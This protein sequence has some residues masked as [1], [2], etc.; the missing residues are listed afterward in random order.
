[1]IK[2]KKWTLIGIAFVLML[3]LSACG[4]NKSAYESL[5]QGTAKLGQADSFDYSGT[6]AFKMDAKPAAGNAEEAQVEQMLS[7]LELKFSGASFKKAKQAT[8]NLELALKGDASL[9]LNVPIVVDQE[10][11]YV[12]VPSIPML[13]LPETVTGKYV[14][15]TKADLEKLSEQAAQENAQKQPKADP[16]KEKQLN[17]ELEA[18]IAKQFKQDDNLIKVSV[19]KSSAEVPAPVKQV[20]E[21]S[22]TNDNF[23]TLVEK[24]VKGLIP[25]ILTVLSKPEYKELTGI[26]TDALKDYQKSLDSFTTEELKKQLTVNKAI[27]QFGIDG[28]GYLSYLRDK[29]D[30][31]ANDE[32]SG[33]TNA[34]ID[35][36][37]NATDINKAKG[38]VAIP[39]ADETI[40]LAQ[41]QEQLG[42]AFSTP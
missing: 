24:I 22:I 40:S 30:F 27:S 34:A 28:S 10:D 29:F 39:K 5:K 15:I 1:M 38:Q 17:K 7:N 31:T 3:S 41:L 26:P 4:Q 23:P 6:L 12:K 14:H 2:F 16:A 25:D 37:F 36:T 20:V 21:Y 19:K 9:S 13:P 18:V 35:F 42:A 32:T 11:I 8:F 33:K